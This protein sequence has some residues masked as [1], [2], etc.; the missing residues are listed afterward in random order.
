M[1]F[2]KS[3]VIGSFRLTFFTTRE[4]STLDFA[5]T[6]AN[7]DSDA[8][9]DAKVLVGESKVRVKRKSQ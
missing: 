4:L 9:T 7:V 6:E 5:G 8:R 2:A 3:K 1:T